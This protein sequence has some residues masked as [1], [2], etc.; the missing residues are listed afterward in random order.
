MGPTRPCIKWVPGG[1][2]FTGA[3]LQ[4]EQRLKLS[5]AIPFVHPACLYGLD[6][7]KLPSLE[8]DWCIYYREITDLGERI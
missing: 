5:G 4:L 1:F 6:R 8:Q 2:F 7:E 3:N